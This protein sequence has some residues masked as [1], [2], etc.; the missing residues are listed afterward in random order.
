MKKLLALT[1]FLSLCLVATA[2]LHAQGNLGGLTGTVGDSTGAS[3]PEVRV[4]LRN[5]QTNAIYRSTSDERG[6]TFSAVVPGLYRLEAEKQGFKKF[7]REQVSILTAT[8]IDL[9]LIL[10]VGAVSDSVTV[11]ADVIALQTTSPEVSTVLQRRQ[12]LDLPIQVGTGSITTA[13]SGRR[14]PEAFVFLTPGVTGS[15][16][17]KSVNGSPEF[18]QEMLIDGI[19]AQLA[20]N[21][22][23]LAQSAPPY[24][25][26]EEFK[27]QNTLFPAEYGR[28]LGVINFTLRSGTNAFHGGLFELFRNDK[29]DARQF[30]AAR[31]AIVRFNETGG[32]LG[33]PLLI[34]KVYNGKDKTFWNFNYTLVRN[35]PPINGSLTS[36]PPAEFRRGDFSRYVDGAGN[37]IPIFDPLTTADDGT[38]QPFAGNLIPQGRASQVAQRAFP[39]IPLP[40]NPSAY[41]N[42]FINRTANRTEDDIWSAKIDHIFNERH[43]VS[44]ATWHSLN[45]GPSTSEF[46]L[47][48]GPYGLW[49]YSVIKGHNYRANYDQTISPNLLHHAGFGYTYSNPTRQR[50]PRAGNEIIQMPGVAKDAPGFPA[51]S[52]AN[53]YGSS[54]IG[55]S[56]QQPNDP[57]ANISWVF[58]DNLTW[59]KGKHQI[60]FGGEGRLLRF[61]NFAGTDTGGLSGLYNFN[62]LSTSNLT[63]AQSNTLGNGWASF[64]LGQVFSGQR[65]IPAPERKM[66]HEFY[67]WFAED[68]FKVTRKLTVTLGFR[69]EIPTVVYERNYR[70]SYLD[71]GLAN[72]G[73]GGRQGA[74]AFLKDGQRLLPTYRTAFSP[75]LGLAYSINPKT[76]IRT[77]Y[78][79]FWSPTNATSI[80]RLSRYF[81]SGFS[82]TQ[83]FPNQTTGRVPAFILD[84]GVP[85]FTG[86][87][88]NTSPTLL[89]NNIID[90]INPG[91]NKPG[92]TNSW[93]F[94]VQRELPFQFLGDFGYVGQFSVGLPA[95]LENINQVPIANLRLGNTLNA[96]INSDAARQAGIGLP[97]A[98]FTGSVAQALRPYPQFTDIRNLLQPTGWNKYHSLQVRM[99]RRFSNG[100]S[101]LIAYTFSKNFI[102]GSGYTGWGDDASAARPLDTANRRLEKRLAQFDTPQNFVLSWTYEMPFGQ[103]KKFVGSPS[104]AVNLLVGG[105]QLNAIHQYNTGTPFGVGGG[106][107]IPLFAGGNRPNRVAGVAPLTGISHGSF[108]PGRDRY[109]NIDAFSQ[110]AAFALGSAAPNYGDM[111]N[112]GTRNENIS[113]L[114]NFQVL[115][116]HNVQFR[117]EFFNAFNR[118]NFGGTAANLN[119]PAT[120]GRITSA[121]PPRSIQLVLKYV[122]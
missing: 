78:G 21:P 63:S 32:S 30:F 57:S 4:T 35:A 70:Q 50:D 31:R 81:N 33:G 22:G 58:Q 3:I 24:E 23:F 65:L 110:P 16:W 90:F 1:P 80:G 108:D 8:T 18:T 85:A 97:Y 49:Y 122:F 40:D 91:S 34:P 15:Q 6:Y 28:G 120:F 42:N 19:S 72:T 106:G 59:I 100:L 10:E 37:Q 96:N 74:L 47:A 118:V 88:P 56:N 12:I 114:K 17:G 43:R 29:L 2:I 79:I 105:W 95:G 69:H 9:P 99:Q 38:R 113:V 20:G 86:T 115:E 66:Q 75:R 93:T 83:D 92:Y 98:G 94:N 44:F 54:T 25:A 71:L 121:A 53:P 101:T 77:G 64:Y 60:K 119:A 27:M 51:F 45:D 82:F 13:A 39:L 61:D 117:A 5:I 103:G 26:I 73:A 104:R 111:R 55:N 14:Q 52:I 84:S 41:V 107:P 11:S 62:S 67:A 89:N 87:L 46:G 112:F 7:V 109:L 48:G 116:G 36:V 102:H 76:V 68:V